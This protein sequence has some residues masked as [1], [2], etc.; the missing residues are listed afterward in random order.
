MG[1][2]ELFR[3]FPGRRVS[4]IRRLVSELPSSVSSSFPA[5]GAV[6]GNKRIR[7]D[8]LDSVVR[9]LASELPSVSSSF[10]AIG[11]VAGNKRIRGNRLDS[12]ASLDPGDVAIDL[13]CRDALD[14]TRTGV[15]VLD[16]L[17]NEAVPDDDR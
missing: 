8:R 16:E 13:T 14:G 15:G 6:A 11:A 1:S 12:A 5:T 9:G 7:G 2:G 4:V 3:C 17:L 10:P